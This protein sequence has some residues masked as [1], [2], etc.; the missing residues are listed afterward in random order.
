MTSEPKRLPEESCGVNADFG[1][2][3]RA[4]MAMGAVGR[5]RTHQV[6][7]S[8][9]SAYA[10][11][12]QH[13]D[14]K[15]QS[16][17]RQQPEAAHTYKMDGVTRPATSRAEQWAG[18]DQE[19]K[20]WMGQAPGAPCMLATPAR[21]VNADPDEVDFYEFKPLE[22]EVDL[23]AYLPGEEMEPDIGAAVQQAHVEMAEVL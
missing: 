9:T 7:V 15:R 6:K 11:S 19:Q 10:R 14:E 18:V 4:R 3:E 16:A 5:R 1:F 21:G 22:G 17:V 13:G 23:K 2:D 8:A 20:Q 12:V